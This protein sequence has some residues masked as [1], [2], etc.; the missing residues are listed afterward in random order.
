GGQTWTDP[1]DAD[2]GL[3]TGSGEYHTAPM[4]VIIHDGHL[5]RSFEDAGGGKKWGIRY[6]AMM[7]SAPVDADLLK[8][9]SW[10][11]SNYVSRNP[12]WMDGTFRAWL[13]G[14]A[15]VSPEGKMLDILRMHY[16]GQG[17]KAAIVQI[18]DDGKTATFDPETGFIDFPG[19]AKKFV[20]RFD[21]QSKAY[22]ALANPVAPIAR[23]Q[24]ENAASIRN[25]LAL[26]RSTDL[27]NWEV[28]CILLYHPDVAKHGFQYPD[29]QFDGNDM[30]AAIR[31]AYDDG[32]G[33]AHN[34]HD[35]N[36]LTFHR[37]TDFRNLTVD[38]SVVDPATLQLPEPTKIETDSLSVEGHGFTV[39]KLQNK[40]QA[41]ANRDYVWKQVPKSLQGWR[42][43][44][45][46]GGVKSQ[47]SVTAKKDGTI[48]VATSSTKKVMDA[49]GW[50]KEPN[51]TFGYTDSKNT[52]M[53][54]L[55]RDMSANDTV[56]LPQ[57]NWGG[58]LL[59]IPPDKSK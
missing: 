43:T 19:G 53:K 13:E 24:K 4:P 11:F 30:I 8:R 27:K 32:L 14:N 15:V 17:G 2:S 5:W 26:M 49:G 22:W 6:R 21:P 54:V 58:T 9:E 20:I 46:S 42:Y 50:R 41:F 25:T 57:L 35:A 59:L 55:C 51:L 48:Y 33:G 10:R 45:T 23:L 12:E 39:E 1:K 16:T 7:L 18:S 31:T 56:E 38:D 52:Q 40:G 44:Q 3:L 47:I 34:A 29:W 36:F 28:R 37:F